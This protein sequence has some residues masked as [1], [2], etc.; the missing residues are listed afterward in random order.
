MSKIG[1]SRLNNLNE[2]SNGGQALNNLFAQVPLSRSSYMSRV[3]ISDINVFNNNLSATT[4]FTYIPANIAFQAN[5]SDLYTSVGG[6]L[7]ALAVNNIS[8][9]NLN[10]N[11]TKGDGISADN[12]YFKSEYTIGSIVPRTFKGKVYYELGFIDNKKLEKV[13]PRNTSITFIKRNNQATIQ[14]NL[15][16]LDKSTTSSFTQG[17]QVDSIYYTF[18][19]TRTPLLSSDIYNYYVIDYQLNSNNQICFGLSTRL[20]GSR[21][22][23][24]GI[25]AL[26]AVSFV[27]NTAITQRNFLN[28]TEPTR[29]DSSY[30]YPY[31]VSNLNSA[32]ADLENNAAY[33]KGILPKKLISTSDNF[34]TEDIHIKG[35][36]K[37]DD[38]NLINKNII[39]DDPY[40]P[41]IYILDKTNNFN[42][43]QRVFSTSEA[44]WQST[45]NGLSATKDLDISSLVFEN[46]ISI[47]RVT[48]NTITLALPITGA[49]IKIPITI[50]NSDNTTTEYYAFASE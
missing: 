17:D 36:L 29:N 5:S 3:T 39:S 22:S 43:K 40:S 48:I 4:T 20:S 45:D 46:G 35:V 37:I 26:S 49:N 25:N 2:I 7:N 31:D 24:S 27:R 30:L 9:S 44:A 8:Y 50:I 34:T 28:T 33:I 10:F 14:N 16:I 19:G 23:L 41:S 21:V 47:N 6:I 1:L 13:V 15:F 42:A 11:I 32:I 12:I 18:D 38:P